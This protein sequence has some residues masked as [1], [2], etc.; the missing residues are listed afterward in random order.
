MSQY[1]SRIFALVFLC[2]CSLQAMAQMRLSEDGTGEVLIFPFY[3]AASGEESSF[4]IRNHTDHAKGVYLRF[5]EGLAGAEVLSFNV[6]LAPND[7][8]EASVIR[9]PGG[10]GAAIASLDSTCT[11]PNLGTPNIAP[12]EGFSQ[13]QPGGETLRI[14]PFVNFDYIDDSDNGAKRTLVGTLEVFEMG[15]WSSTSNSIAASAFEMAEYATA[16]AQGD[17]SGCDR[18]VSAWTP[19]APSGIWLDSPAAGAMPWSGGGMSGQMVITTAR[20]KL[21][22]PPLAIKGFA[23]NELAAEYHV[24]PGTAEAD[25][26]TPSLA[27][28]SRSVQSPISNSVFSASSGLNAISILLAKTEV[29]VGQPTANMGS[30]R[31]VIVSFPTKR[32]HTEGAGFAP[33]KPFTSRWNPESLSA[34]ESIAF[35]EGR[36][37]LGA[38][39]FPS[40]SFDELCGAI[41]LLSYP[42][43]PGDLAPE[44]D[45]LAGAMPSLTEYPWVM[46][47]ARTS[48][49]RDGGE[50][51][52]VV[53]GGFGS[54]ASLKGMP[55]I[56]IPLGVNKQGGGWL[57]EANL[58]ARIEYTDNT[59]NSAGASTSSST[60]STSDCSGFGASY[61]CDSD[62]GVGDDPAGDSGSSSGSGS[63]GAGSDTSCDPNYDFGCSSGSGS[64][65]GASDGSGSS[66]G[67]GSAD[68]SSDTECDPKYDFGCSSGSGSSSD[69]S[70][71]SGSTSGWGST[72]AGSGTGGAD[73]STGTDTGTS[74]GGVSGTTD[75]SHF[76]KLLL[77]V[78]RE[79]GVYAGIGA[80]QGWALDDAGYLNSNLDLYIDGQYQ[81]QIAYGNTRGDVEAAYPS[82]PQSRQSGFAA[83]FNYAQLPTGWHELE[84]VARDSAG[85]QLRSAVNFYVERFPSGPYLSGA[86][87]PKAAGG[88]SCRMVTDEIICRDV[89][90]GGSSVDI[91]FEWSPASQN[92]EISRIDAN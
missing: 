8:F 64:S 33:K 37:T 69:A 3:S 10:D 73:T 72:D 21:S 4:V 86:N 18:L 38:F 65:G 67:S 89:S 12:F 15:Q 92:F 23:R 75:S 35:A 66:S 50:Y 17:R 59:G 61:G 82:V 45:W 54:A 47:F 68:T 53:N 16:S 49:E 29:S 57:K 48:F 81:G 71:D 88:T 7:S 5:R 79:G 28:G 2:S 46:S 87:A 14:Q 91:W 56:V 20:G 1:V 90:L 39:P 43:S 36:D 9:N 60:G 41:N 83:T 34:C 6:Y 26:P 13:Q 70:D 42:D 63:A 44:A 11:V 62:A 22:V 19:T 24:S 84:V 76:S 32:L 77:E 51:D 52:R 30:S 58:T 80:I 78:P 40:A 85:R 27:N 25:W 74:S 31:E 55:V